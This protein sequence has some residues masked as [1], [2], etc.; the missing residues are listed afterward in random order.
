MSASSFASDHCI[1]VTTKHAEVTVVLMYKSPGFSVSAMQGAI[2]EALKVNNKNV[3]YI[4]DVNMDLSK[5]QGEY[6]VKIFERYGLVSKLPL[7]CQTTNLGSVL[8]VCFSDKGDCHA[9]V[10]ESYYSYH[11]PILVTWSK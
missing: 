9:T 10:Y 5:K 3:I 2:E 1:L 6:L 8:D 4:G 7:N 11:K